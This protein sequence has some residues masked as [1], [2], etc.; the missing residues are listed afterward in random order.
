MSSEGLQDF[1]HRQNELHEG[2]VADRW[3]RWARIMSARFGSSPLHHR[4]M[5]MILLMQQSRYW[6]TTAYHFLPQIKLSIAPLLREVLEK[7]R[8]A[9][10]GTQRNLEK[11]IVHWQ[12]VAMPSEIQ[13]KFV[14]QE[15]QS[16]VNDHRLTSV[17]AAMMT[18]LRRVL[19]RFEENERPAYGQRTTVEEVRQ[20]VQRVVHERQRV[21]DKAVRPAMMQQIKRVMREQSLE[22]HPNAS[23][24]NLPVSQTSFSAAANVDKLTDQIVRQIDQ[25]MVAYRERFGKAF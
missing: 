10:F 9:V 7:R 14:L 6:Q 2:E 5:A 25:R 12:R 11:E 3:T 20:I 19:Q 13:Q 22:D 17:A 21:E 4:G 1:L 24:T 23:A 18:P 8:S 15:N 16:E